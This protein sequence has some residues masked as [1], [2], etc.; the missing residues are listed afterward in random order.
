M[1]KIFIFLFLLS[2]LL[3]ATAIAQNKE[4][5]VV[6]GGHTINPDESIFYNLSKSGDHTVLT[7]G[8]RAAGLE[9]LLSGKGD[10]TLIAPL[11]DPI[12]HEIPAGR[13]EQ[14]FNELLPEQQPEMYEIIAYHIL[15]GRYTIKA[16]TDA[17]QVGGG[18]TLLATLGGRVLTATQNKAGAI[19]LTDDYGRKATLIQTDI[20]QSNGI[21][22]VASE[23]LLPQGSLKPRDYSKDY[24]SHQP[25]K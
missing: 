16:L 17:I 15:I 12:I 8:I 7:A 6:L 9:K 23:A 18:K 10:F 11:S 14:L 4:G 1:K 21:I 2:C 25:K 19:V 24:K 3:S 20:T 22:H 13:A 5:K